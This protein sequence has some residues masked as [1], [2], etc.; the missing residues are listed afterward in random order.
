MGYAKDDSLVTP[1]R[2]GA[3]T[4]CCRVK[5]GLREKRAGVLG[6]NIPAGKAAKL[7]GLRPSLEKATC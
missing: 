6:E 1:W 3:G 5:Q 4:A 2:E 7:C